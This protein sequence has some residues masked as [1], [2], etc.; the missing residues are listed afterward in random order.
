MQWCA[1]C[2]PPKAC[3]RCAYRQC[4]AD[5]ECRHSTLGWPVHTWLYIAQT[6]ARLRDVSKMDSWLMP[7]LK[8]LDPSPKSAWPSLLKA[9]SEWLQSTILPSSIIGRPPSVPAKALEPSDAAC[10][11]SQVLVP[12]PSPCME[13]AAVPRAVMH[14]HTCCRVACMK[15]ACMHTQEH[16][17]WY[18]RT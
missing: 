3:T 13:Q 8:C 2:L 6:C 4:N 5:Q 10:A 1:T 14:L 11:R 15:L 16:A 9:S 7:P 18:V 17:V 12:A